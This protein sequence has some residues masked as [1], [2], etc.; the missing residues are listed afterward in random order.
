MEVRVEVGRTVEA[1]AS[2]V[3]VVPADEP[4]KIEEG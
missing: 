4:R 1:G 2:W 3:G